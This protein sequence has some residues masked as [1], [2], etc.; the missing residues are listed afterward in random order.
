[1]QAAGRDPMLDPRLG[2]LETFEI[3]ARQHPMLPAGQSP[4]R[5]ASRCMD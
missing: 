2:E 3:A 5:R 1:M 4:G